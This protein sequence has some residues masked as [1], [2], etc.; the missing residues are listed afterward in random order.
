M[1]L[2]LMCGIESFKT[3]ITSS[4]SGFYGPYKL[5]LWFCAPGLTIHLPVSVRKVLVS[6]STVTRIA[7]DIY[8][9]VHGLRTEKRQVIRNRHTAK[10]LPKSHA[11]LAEFQPQ[12]LVHWVR[13]PPSCERSV[14][15]AG[16]QKSNMKD[17][18][19]TYTSLNTEIT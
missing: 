6:Y 13:K 15:T 8:S 1:T 11:H 2:R 10:R 4:V 19:A 14:N 3:N 9:S 18:F 7:F 16:R 12:P 17:Y 5:L